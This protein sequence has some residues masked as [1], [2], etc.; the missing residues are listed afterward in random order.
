ME[1]YVEHH[2]LKTF[3][4]KIVP[5]MKKFEETMM[6]YAREQTQFRDM[7]HRF[8]EVLLLKAS[9][10]ALE[11]VDGRFVDFCTLGDLASA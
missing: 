8:D 7:V 11:N 4:S 2:D 6:N 5:E 3:Y 10:Q 9:K 1:R